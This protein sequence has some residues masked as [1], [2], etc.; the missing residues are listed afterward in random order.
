MK[1]ELSNIN[2]LN[3]IL[4]LVNLAYRGNKG[5]TTEADIVDGARTST[6]AI[7][8]A[9]EDPR[10]HLLVYTEN[11]DLRSCICLYPK[12]DK[13]Y[14]GLFAVHPGA[15]GKGIGTQI[16]ATA[17]AYATT[18]LGLSKYVMAVI[19]QRVELICYYERRGYV[20]SEN[21]EPYPVHLDAGIPKT[22]RLTIEYLEKNV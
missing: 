13:A 7:R 3:D 11:G 15:Q 9:I 20:R 1:L 21:I 4:D 2:Q 22:D 8:H 12:S 5:W 14:I 19:S 18:N 6:R 10:S 16:L 17:E